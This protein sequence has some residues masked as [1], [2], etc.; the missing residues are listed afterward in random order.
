MPDM[1]RKKGCAMSIKMEFTRDE[2]EYVR[3]ALIMARADEKQDFINGHTD[4][5]KWL[6]M[7]EKLVDRCDNMVVNGGA[8]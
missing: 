2:F 5:R 6:S 1:I 4:D 8:F 7:A 3:Y